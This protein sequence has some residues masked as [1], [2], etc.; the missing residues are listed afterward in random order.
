MITPPISLLS[1]GIVTNDG[2]VHCQ[3]LGG[4]GSDAGRLGAALLALMPGVVLA[5]C[6]GRGDASGSGNRKPSHQRA[7]PRPCIGR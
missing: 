7:P 3:R 5:G 1:A 6:A 4:P 2:G